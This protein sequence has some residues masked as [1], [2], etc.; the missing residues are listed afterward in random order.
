MITL[1]FTKEQFILLKSAVD[2]HLDQT[3]QYLGF[4]LSPDH[5]DQEEVNCF[6]K[7]RDDLHSLIRILD[8][9]DL[10]D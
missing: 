5:F 1:N 8:Q 4:Y 9:I 10:K 7:E 6:R 3:V 2:I